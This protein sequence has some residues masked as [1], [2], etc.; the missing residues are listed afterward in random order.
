MTNARVHC[1]DI[2]SFN[3]NDKPRF[4][5]KGIRPNNNPGIVEDSND[6]MQLACIERCLCVPQGQLMDNRIV[7][8]FSVLVIGCTSLGYLR[9]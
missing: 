9:A 4:F 3:R 1:L 8:D 2:A 6:S 7:Y 5:P